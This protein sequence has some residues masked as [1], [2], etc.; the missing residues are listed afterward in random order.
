MNIDL[1]Q[2]ATLNGIAPSDNV[3]KR[4]G[5]LGQGTV[6]EMVMRGLDY[7]DSG[8]MGVMVVYD[9]GMLDATKIQEVA[10]QIRKNGFPIGT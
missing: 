7:V 1:E 4:G 6:A 10:A 9:G 8:Y 5:T 2:Q 3:F